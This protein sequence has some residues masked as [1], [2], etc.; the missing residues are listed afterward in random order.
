MSPPARVALVASDP[1]ALR[2]YRLGLSRGVELA[3]ENP[4]LVAALLASTAWTIAREW[5]RRYS[6]PFPWAR[7]AWRIEPDVDHADRLDVA[8]LVHL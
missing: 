1:A 3:D 5:T 6:V 4:E 8:E 2:H 7:V